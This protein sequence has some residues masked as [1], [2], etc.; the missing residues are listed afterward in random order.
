VGF[1]SA[2]YGKLVT[3]SLDEFTTT[4]GSRSINLADER[5]NVWTIRGGSN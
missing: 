5:E 2:R 4:L 1:Y 3:W